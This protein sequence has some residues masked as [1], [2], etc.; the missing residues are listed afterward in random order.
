VSLQTI[1]DRTRALQGPWLI[2][3]LVITPR[4]YAILWRFRNSNLFRFLSNPCDHAG[5]QMSAS[6][7]L[8]LPHRLL[9][10]VS[11]V[12]S[13]TGLFN[14]PDTESHPSRTFAAKLMLHA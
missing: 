2:H 4:D 8:F 1:S 5:K 10:S 6:L 11:E 3:C 9:E 7:A 13:I 12:R 14:A